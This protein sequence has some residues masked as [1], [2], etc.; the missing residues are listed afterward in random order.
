[1]KKSNPFKS[2]MKIRLIN[3]FI[4]EAEFVNYSKGRLNTLNK[5]LSNNLINEEIE[6]RFN[7]QSK[8]HLS[9]SY[10]GL[11][12]IIVEMFETNLWNDFTENELKFKSFI[13]DNFIK[14]I[15]IND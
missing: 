15:T 4:G 12:I 8:K 13:Y 14:K 9:S 11:L 6:H 10:Y 1:M 2:K 7:Y 5:F 3:S